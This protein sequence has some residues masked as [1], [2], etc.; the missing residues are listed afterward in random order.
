VIF[1]SSRLEKRGDAAFHELKGAQAGAVAAEE[2]W[3]RARKKEEEEAAEAA[4]GT[5]ARSAKKGKYPGYSLWSAYATSKLGNIMTVY[6]MHKAMEQ[7][8][9]ESVERTG[10]VVCAVVTPGVVN[11]ELGRFAP[12]WLLFLSWPLRRLLMR[13]PD[14]GSVSTV[15]AAASPGLVPGSYVSGDGDVIKSSPESYDEQ[16]WQR[17]WDGSGEAVGL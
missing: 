15:Y 8:R 10:R 12:S 7:Q 11:S 16:S 1:V 13:Q 4:G 9:G 3:D 17:L 5:P 6:Q 14:Q 2:A